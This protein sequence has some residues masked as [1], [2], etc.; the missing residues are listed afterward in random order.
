[1]LR[2]SSQFFYQS[3]AVSIVQ[4]TAFASTR[5]LIASVISGTKV[6]LAGQIYT[7]KADYNGTLGW[8]NTLKW[9]E[10][11]FTGGQMFLSDAQ[12]AAPELFVYLKLSSASYGT[13]GT[14]AFSPN[15]YDFDGYLIPNNWPVYNRTDYESDEKYQEAEQS[16]KA[17]DLR[18]NIAHIDIKKLEDFCSVADNNATFLQQDDGN[19]FYIS[20]GRLYVKDGVR[21]FEAWDTAHPGG[22]LGTNYSE[23]TGDDSMFSIYESGGKYI[24]P[25]MPFWQLAIKDQLMLFGQAIKNIVTSADSFLSFVKRGSDGKYTQGDNTLV[26]AA[27]VDKNFVA[28]YRDDDNDDH[29][30]TLG[31]V[32][33][34]GKK[35]DT[36]ESDVQEEEQVPSSKPAEDLAIFDHLDRDRHGAGVYRDQQ[37]FLHLETD[38]LAVHNKLTAKEVEI[39]EVN[40]VGGSIVLTPAD[41]FKPERVVPVNLVDGLWVDAPSTTPVPDISTSG[42]SGVTTSSPS[43]GGAE[44]PAPPDAYKLMWRAVNADGVEIKNMWKVGD[45]ALAQTFNVNT[46]SSQS[47]GSFYADGISSAFWWRVVLDVNDQLVTEST[48]ITD[49]VD[50]QT[51]SVSVAY[52]YIIVSNKASDPMHVAGTDIPHAGDAVVMLGHQQQP[53]ENEADA[54]QRQSAIVLLAATSVPS[55]REYTG[56]NTLNQLTDDNCAVQIQPDANKFTGT[57]TIENVEWND[58]NLPPQIQ[59]LINQYNNLYAQLS[60]L[61]GISFNYV[62]NSAFLGD[63]LSPQVEG[64]RVVSGDTDMATEHLVHWNIAGADG[65]GVLPDT[66]LTEDGSIRYWWAILVNGTLS[67]RLDMVPSKGVA[68]SMS[69]LADSSADGNVLTMTLGDL[70]HEFSLTKGQQ[71]CTL[72]NFTLSENG[73]V[74][75][76]S[77]SA[78]ITRIMLNPGTKVQE[79]GFNVLDN[80]DTTAYYSNLHYLMDAMRNGKTTISGGLILSSLINLG[81]W[82]KGSDGNDIFTPYSGMN[83]QINY[84][85]GTPTPNETPAFWAGGALESSDGSIGNAVTTLRFYSRHPHAIP[86]DFDRA[87]MVNAVIA[88]DGTA[89]FNK[90]IVRGDIYADNGYFKGNITGAT[91]TFSGRIEANEGYFK[92]DI[93]GARG[94]FSGAVNIANGMIQFHENGDGSLAGGKIRWDGNGGGLMIDGTIQVT[95]GFKYSPV[96][97]GKESMGAMI[98]APMA[99]WVDDSDGVLT[100]PSIIAAHHGLQVIVVNAS[101]NKNAKL[102]IAVP[103]TENHRIRWREGGELQEETSMTIL[104][105]SSVTF[106]F[107]STDWYFVARSY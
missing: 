92:G 87:N 73:S 91:G 68:F 24:L 34:V 10:W 78:R 46:D 31:Q 94:T 43:E 106:I 56:I 75:S 41:G 84:F 74:L 64:D 58:D 69:F 30:L 61:Q 103:A 35:W 89:V 27:A 100:L 55:I 65:T 45:Q 79:W 77:G 93:T 37:G 81:M 49:S 14:M 99:I 88:M 33:V 51:E 40:Y 83:G 60:A 12:D 11:A 29:L 15:N 76:F 52:H 8:S 1:M 104:A 23:E 48:P 97:Y 6:R 82:T 18:R 39:Q 66:E 86:S 13:T 62:R 9:R 22:T 19:S 85:D 95:E 54:K 63:F 5:Y 90:A 36:P 47:H 44:A 98:S 20:I 101:E 21:I 72:E 67:Q 96:L 70:T 25:S 26:T 80:T 53:D 28:R 2:D 38:Y 50:N 7:H 105:G 102:T 42:I 16:A 107:A 57:V 71:L 3:N 4:A 32:H 17:I 59:T